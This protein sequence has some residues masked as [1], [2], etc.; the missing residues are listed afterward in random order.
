MDC[1][2]LPAPIIKR[3]V[4]GR[5]RKSFSSQ[6]V[7]RAA[8][9]SD[10]LALAKAAWPLTRGQCV[11]L[12]TSKSTPISYCLVRQRQV[13]VCVCVCVCV[14]VYERLSQSRTRK[15][16]AWELNGILPLD[17]QLKVQRTDHY[18]TE[19]LSVRCA[20][21]EQ[22]FIAMRCLALS[23]FCCRSNNDV[24]DDVTAKYECSNRSSAV[25]GDNFAAV[26]FRSVNHFPAVRP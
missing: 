21:N 20:T 23:L 12:F 3:N 10:S 11:A 22:I 14:F 18:T 17:L 26:L 19:P 16:T 4:L 2:Y 24:T 13:C 25:D 9:I 8:S 1:S 15:R 5:L 6:T 7:H